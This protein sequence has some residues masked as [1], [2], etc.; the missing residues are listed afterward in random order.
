[1]SAPKHGALPPLP[2][3]ARSLTPPERKASGSFAL[4]DSTPSRTLATQGLGALV[5]VF[6]ELSPMQRERLTELGYLFARLSPEQVEELVDLA[7]EMNGLG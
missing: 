2:I 3:P 1:M 5:S 7:I 4:E 6:E